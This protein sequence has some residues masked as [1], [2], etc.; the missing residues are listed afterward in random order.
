MILGPENRKIFVQSTC[1]FDEMLAGRTSWRL[2]SLAALLRDLLF[3]VVTQNGRVT[4]WAWVLSIC[5]VGGWVGGCCGCCGCGCGGGCCCGC[6]G[7][8]WQIKQLLDG[9]IEVVV[10]TAAKT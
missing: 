9:V 4:A 1:R 10:V 5:W 2:C 3:H 8:L 6:C 7:H